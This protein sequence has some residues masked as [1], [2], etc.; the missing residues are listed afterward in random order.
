MTFP[1]VVEC[2]PCY[3]LS[4]PVIDACVNNYSPFPMIHVYTHLRNLLP[5]Y[6]DDDNNNNNEIFYFLPLHLLTVLA[7]EVDSTS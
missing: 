1:I 2:A 3:Y 5:C 6:V 4:L 7:R